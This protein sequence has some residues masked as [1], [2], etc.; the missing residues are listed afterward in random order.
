MFKSDPQMDVLD[1]KEPF[2]CLVKFSSP[3][4]LE[5]L[6]SLAPAGK[7]SNST[8]WRRNPQLNILVILHYASILHK[9]EPSQ[10]V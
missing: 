8:K 6:K 7:F 3:H 5:S 1:K 10:F 4:L 9:G 2:R